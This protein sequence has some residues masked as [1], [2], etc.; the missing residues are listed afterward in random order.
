MARQVS[1]SGGRICPLLQ[2][3]IPS[4]EKQGLSVSPYSSRT[5]SSDSSIIPGSD[6]FLFF[7]T[8]VVIP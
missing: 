7:P 1:V 2:I 4:K 3:S 6:S 5:T 8:E